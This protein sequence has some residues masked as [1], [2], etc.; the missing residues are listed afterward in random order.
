M[1][2]IPQNLFE[3]FLKNSFLEFLPNED[4]KVLHEHVTQVEVENNQKIP[5]EE[6][7]QNLYFCYTGSVVLKHRH[8]G[9]EIGR[10]RSGQSLDFRTLLLRSPQWPHDWVAEGPVSIIKFPWAKLEQILTKYPLQVAYLTKLAQ[11][12]SLQRLKRDLLALGFSPEF[13]FNLISRLA[14]MPGPTFTQMAQQGQLTGSLFLNVANGDLDITYGPEVIRKRRFQIRT[15]QSLYFSHFLPSMDNTFQFYSETRIFVLADKDVAALKSLPEFTKFDETFSKRQDSPSDLL[16]DSNADLNSEASVSQSSV[17]SKFEETTIWSR[18]AKKLHAKK[19]ST[20]PWINDLKEAFKGFQFGEASI[21]TQRYDQKIAILQ[22]LFNFFGAQFKPYEFYS[23]ESFFSNDLRINDFEYE[24]NRFGFKVKLIPNLN[25]YDVRPDRWYIAEYHKTLCLFRFTE[26]GRVRVLDTVN[27]QYQTIPEDNLL[28]LIDQAKVLELS[29]LNMETA[30]KKRAIRYVQYFKWNSLHKLIE[31]KKVFVGTLLACS[32]WIYIFSLSLP[33]ATQYMLDQV[34]QS[35]RVDKLSLLAGALLV[36]TLLSSYFESVQ[37]N[38]STYLSSLLSFRIKHTIHQNLFESNRKKDLNISS[39]AVI[40]RLTE[41][42]P[43][44]S[45]Y[46]LQMMPMITNSLLVFLTLIIV[47]MYSPLVAL[48]FFLFI[49]LSGFVVYLRRNQIRNLKNNQFRTK[50]RE[51]RSLSDAYL[52]HEPALV[53]QQNVFSRWKIESNF[54]SL[55]HHMGLSALIQ[56]G[57]QVLQVV[58]SEMLRIVTFLLSISLYSKGELTLGQVLALTMIAPRFGS[59]LQNLL[60]GYY[61]RFMLEAGLD[62]LNELLTEPNGRDRDA[63]FAFTKVTIED[64]SVGLKAEGLSF[65]SKASEALLKDVNFTLERGHQLVILGANHFAKDTLVQI[66]AGAESGFSGR[67][68]RSAAFSR[69][70]L[71][72]SELNLLTGSLSYNLTL[73]DINPDLNRLNHII[74]SLG[75]ETELL[76]RQE[77]LNFSVQGT[78]NQFS[79]SD[80]K[81]ILLVRALYQEPDMLVCQN[82]DDYFDILTEHEV[83]KSVRKLMNKGILVWETESFSVATK[84]SHVLYLSDGVAKVVV[85][86]RE[87]LDQSPEYKNFFV[88][89]LSINV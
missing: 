9:F 67:L 89:K 80:I 36:L 43:L 82:M 76:G 21:S 75:F 81:R 5:R 7:A 55:N 23:R 59:L 87:L 50:D 56:S 30:E 70:A 41:V 42:E 33:I 63:D 15:G 28:H 6:P 8:H 4:I 57:L 19:T 38:V 20:H 53:H 54:E 34:S 47:A 12:P 60:N 78:G 18:V 46:I 37:Q 31:D 48:T 66:I 29:G 58:K 49:P 16:Y 86:H 26:D 44:I 73:D 84:T 52:R 39:S 2:K 69:T 77:G 64:G 68:V 22:E 61:Q 45:S 25:G 74:S 32:F 13:I 85:S 11:S 40:S 14:L 1:I 27:G 65:M 83:F 17:R 24:L 35:G 3:D 72:S 51:L 71:V 79:P 10:I 88:Q 62:K